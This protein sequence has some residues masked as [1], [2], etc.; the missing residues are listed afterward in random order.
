[1]TVDSA[2]HPD[3]EASS[4][5]P[6]VDAS[7][8]VARPY[9]V[10]SVV[11]LA[12]AL[13]LGV[14]AAL[15]LVAP[16]LNAGPLTY[17]RVLPIA[18]DL[19]L[20]G[21][22]TIGLAGA[23][24]HVV[25]RSGRVAVAGGRAAT[26]ALGLMA[27]GVVAGSA[28]IAAGLNEGRQ[29]LEYPLWADAALLL[30]MA[31]FA[32][33]LVAT[34][35]TATVDA[36]P[37]RW[38]AVA[39]AWWLPLGFLA[40]NVPGIA[41][42]GG[43]AQT[44]FFRAAI[45][46]LWLAAGGL[47]VVYHLVAT[48]TGRD[49]FPATRLSLLGFWSIA[50]V[51]AL[52]APAALTYTVAPDWLETIGVIFSMGLFIPAAVVITDLVVAM[53]RRWQMAA[54]DPSIR[55][56]V[57]GGA[58]FGLWPV[59]NLAMA[60][61]SSS[62]IV[63]YT[64]WVSGVE[65]VG[66]YGAFTAWLV[67]FAYHAAGARASSRAGRLHHAGMATGLLAWAG[68][69]FLG[70]ATAGWTWVANANEAAVPAAGAG[71]WNTLRAVE[72]FTVVSLVGRVMYGAAFVGF[73]I[74]ALRHR[75]MV[76]PHLVTGDGD[77]IDV[78][79]TLDSAVGT[80]KVQRA[81]FGLFAAA[82]VIVLVLPWAE[83]A[84][85]DGSLLADTARIYRDGSLDAE[86]RTLYVAEGCWYC[87]TQQ[88][89][90]IVTDVGLGAVSAAGDYVHETPALYGVQRIGPDL[91]HVGQ[92]PPTDDAAWLAAYLAD[93]RSERGY[94]TMPAYD[95]LSDRQL[96]ALAAYLAGSK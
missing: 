44:A 36:G 58:L 40:G 72:P 12:L 65:V 31:V 45:V 25:S 2:A 83:T 73:V 76:E 21:W 91:M 24:L 46:G 34:A 33:T 41:G 95:H 54:G 48:H 81:A 94:S 80:R 37:V 11:F 66:V 88:V 16:G 62:G 55:F 85:V 14:L 3:S 23:L 32:R 61:R 13:L 15:Q 19:F 70:G 77:A 52:T 6:P 60:L 96:E 67:A 51:W 69:A 87:H 10:T 84:G 43:V 79:L 38:Y 74:G 56:V 92:R 86:G 93:P 39:A 1:V 30:G 75:E 4:L 57:L 7:V 42:F 47:A 9:L 50:V 28:G 18:T 29:Y 68:G 20:Y 63:Q 26:A 8:M 49:T 59:A 71:F 27:F 64:D 89:R 17:G 78:E 5:T 82:A 90:A 35:K 22:L 53:R